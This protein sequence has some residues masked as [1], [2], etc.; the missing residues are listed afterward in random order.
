[1]THT[2][3]MYFGSEMHIFP[4]KQPERLVRDAT[5]QLAQTQVKRECDRHM[6]V[7][8]AAVKLH[9]DLCFIASGRV[10]TVSSSTYFPFL[11]KLTPVLLFVLSMCTFDLNISML[12]SVIVFCPFVFI[13]Q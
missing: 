9:V 13:L 7:Q 12:I 1:M 2:F 11:T 6:F 5:T 10:F 8:S 3:L 4:S